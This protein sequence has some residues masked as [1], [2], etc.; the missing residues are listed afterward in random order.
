MQFSKEQIKKAIPST[1]NYK[2]VENNRDIATLR[3]LEIEDLGVV[4]KINAVVETYGYENEC[5]I[6][7]NKDNDV[8]KMSCSC[9]YCDAEEGCGHVAYVLEEINEIH[10]EQFPYSLY[11]KEE[12]KQ[13]REDDYFNDI[14]A[15]QQAIIERR[16]NNYE[17]EKRKREEEQKRLLQMKQLNDTRN[18]VEQYRSKILNSARMNLVKNQIQ[19]E[20]EIVENNIYAFYSSKRILIRFRIGEKKKYVI[21]NIPELLERIEKQQMFSYGKNLTFLHREDA[22]DDASI[23]QL[24]FIKKCT[25]YLSSNPTWYGTFQELRIEENHLDEFYD[26]YSELS[27]TYHKCVFI[28][29]KWGISLKVEEENEYYCISLENKEDYNDLYYGENYIYKIHGSYVTRLV[30]DDKGK[31]KELLMYLKNEPLLIPKTEMLDFYKYVLSDIEEYIQLP[32]DFHTMY[33]KYEDEIRLYGDLDDESTMHIKVDYYVDGEKFYAFTK[34]AQTSLTMDLIETCIRSYA[35]VIDYDAHKAYIQEEE[36]FYLFIREGL[37]YL[38]QYCD[39][40]V[41]DALKQMEKPQSSGIQIG[42]S[43]KEKLIDLTIKSM[44]INKDEVMD[45]LRTYRKKKKFH[46][47]KNGELLFLHEEEW[48]EL[49]ETLEDLHIN[50]KDIK[51]GEAQ[52]PLYQ[53]F[54]LESMEQKNQ[55]QMMRNK[56]FLSMMDHFK[57]RDIH[58]FVVPET[59]RNVLRD[60]QVFGYQW[61]KLLASYGFGGI[62]ADD[63]GLGKTIQMMAFLESEVQSGKPAF[64]ICPA[65]LI[66]NWKDEINKFTNRLNVL[67]ISGNANRRKELIPICKQY[68]VVVTSYDYIRR[69]ITLYEDIRFSTIVLDEAQYIKNQKTKSAEAVK[70]LKS[71]YRFALSGTPIENSLAELWS[72]FDFLM[73]GYLYNYSFF[74]TH[75]EKRIIRENDEKAMEKLKRLVEPFILRRNKKEVLTELPDKIETS[76]YFHFSEEEEKIYQAHAV[77]ASKELRE[78]L[79]FNKGDHIDKVSILSMLTK[80]RQICCEPRLLFDQIEQTSSKM[81]GCMDLIHTLKENKQK[82]LLFSSFT[83]I[84]DL[85]EE[86]LYK[87]KISYYKLTGSTSKEKRKELVEAFQKDDTDVFLISL[88]AGGTGLNLTAAQAVIHYDPWW[89]VSAQ[90][91]A[92]DRAYRIGQKNE[93]QVFSLLMKDSIEEKIQKLQQHKKELA[94]HFVEHNEGSLAQMNEDDFLYLFSVD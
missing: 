29:K 50:I 22:F 72:I 42:L 53:A 5:T 16:K 92:S 30:L 55:L 31:T 35:T 21:K 61:L 88:K 1:K 3:E 80:L 15:R 65:S 20:M 47:L 86:E 84:L 62:L 27:E 7:V 59:Y 45:V 43:V 19:L 81:R 24:H 58:S 68:D 76:V 87:D 17:N 8:V 34:D 33:N 57:K 82:V 74:Q 93:V 38:A 71:D 49:D 79:R 36:Q 10:P 91:Q 28:E 14:L 18:F 4:Y 48:K 78:M 94:D 41:S 66:Y 67:C 75:Y 40:Y 25:S 77:Q 70:K 63:M 54:T 85:L 51:N 56:E 64:V 83:S 26:L 89:N 52:L 2:W 32:I 73:P 44:K 60:Y 13:Q 11:G 9:P 23:E 37:S 39:I 12:E 69:D 90:N 46:R 6:I